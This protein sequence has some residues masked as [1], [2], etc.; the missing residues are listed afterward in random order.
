ML[1]KRIQEA[2]KGHDHGFARMRRPPLQAVGKSACRSI[3]MVLWAHQLP[4]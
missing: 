1:L 2:A 4:T 3:D